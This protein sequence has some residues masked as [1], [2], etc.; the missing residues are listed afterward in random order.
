MCKYKKPI[1]FHAEQLGFQKYCLRSFL[2]YFTF[3]FFTGTPCSDVDIA[4]EPK[5]TYIRTTSI[6]LLKM[7]SKSPQPRWRQRDPMHICIRGHKN[8]SRVKRWTPPTLKERTI[9]LMPLALSKWA[10]FQQK[11]SSESLWN[12]SNFTIP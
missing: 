1:E 2:L 11:I 3:A 6:T 9:F 5:H 8:A 7:N 12:A 10:N 4:S